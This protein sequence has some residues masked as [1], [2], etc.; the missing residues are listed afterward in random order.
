MQLN[1]GFIECIDTIRF[2][3]RDHVG[4]QLGHIIYTYY[5][6][7]CVFLVSNMIMGTHF[8]YFSGVLPSF[9]SNYSNF[10]IPDGSIVYVRLAYFVLLSFCLNT[11]VR[12]QSPLVRKYDKLTPANLFFGR[13]TTKF[14][15]SRS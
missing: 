8:E 10:G 12:G 9:I 14:A 1:S 15:E 13:Q 3:S 4:V 7:F 6:L 5:I 11:L 2:C